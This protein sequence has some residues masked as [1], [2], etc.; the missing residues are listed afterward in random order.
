MAYPVKCKQTGHFQ[1]ST[2]SKTAISKEYNHRSIYARIPIYA[3]SRHAFKFFLAFGKYPFCRSAP[4]HVMPGI[5]LFT[6]ADQILWAF[7]P[8]YPRIIIVVDYHR[9]T[10]LSTKSAFP[11]LH[12]FNSEPEHFPAFGRYVRPIFSLRHPST[13]PQLYSNYPCQPLIKKEK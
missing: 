12:P 2:V 10:D 8:T 13:I 3:T 9:F 4:Y 1:T 7:L 11:L 6:K 5:A